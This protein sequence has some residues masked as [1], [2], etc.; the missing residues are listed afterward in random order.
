MFDYIILSFKYIADQLK[1]ELSA[2]NYLLSKC[3]LE[4]NWLCPYGQT[5]CLK[6]DPWRFRCF[7]SGKLIE[8]SVLKSSFFAK[9]KSPLDSQ[10]IVLIYW[11]NGDSQQVARDGSRLSLKTINRLYSLLNTLCK[12]YMSR[13]PVT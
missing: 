8:R 13:F 11:L 6:S 1:D 5:H 12:D 10:L 9:S 7:C 2:L 4:T 3:V